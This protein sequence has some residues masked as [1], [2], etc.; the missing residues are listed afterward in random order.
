M[1][2]ECTELAA[3]GLESTVTV[4]IDRWGVP[5]IAASSRRD[6]FFAQGF[7]AA[8]DRLFQLDLWRRRGLGLLADVLGRDYVA[9]DRAA[10]LFLYR[11]ALTDE[12]AAYGEHA[13]EI[14]TAFTDGI[15]EW[16]ARTESDPRLLPPEFERLAFRPGRWRPEDVVRIRT[17]GMFGNLEQQVLR[18]VTLRELGPD[19]EDLRKHRQ[20]PIDVVVPDGLDLNSIDESVLD[21][22]RLAL[23][24]AISPAGVGARPP[25]GSNNWVIS[26]DRTSTR[27]PLLASDPHRAMTVPS[28]RYLVHL[29][30]PGID[31]IGAGEP[32]LPGVSIG[33]NEHVAF[34]LTSWPCSQEDLYVYE[35]HPTDRLHYRYR[36]AWEPFTTVTEAVAVADGS[37][38][39]VELMF[40]R[41]GPVIRWDAE[42]G[43]AFAVRA[44]GLE[45]GMAPYLSSLHY[46]DARSAADF[47]DALAHWRAPSVNQVYADVAGEIGWRGCALV[48][49]RDNWDGLLPVP[50]DG[51]YEWSGFRRAEELP[52]VVNPA[53][54]WFASA[55]EMNLDDVHGWQAIPISYE[56]LAPFRAQRI[57]E[58]LS[59]DD[60]MSVASAAALQNDY[61]SIPARAVCALLPATSPDGD[62]AANAGLRLL[63]GWEHTMTADSAAA[64]LFDDWFRGEL[65]ERSYGEALAPFV[66]ADRSVDA[67]RRAMP[68]ESLVGDAT[69]DMLLL[70]RLGADSHRLQRLLCESLAAT[71]RRL[72][73]HHGADETRWRYGAARHTR[74]PHL[75]YGV[76]EAGDAWRATPPDPK[77]GSPDTVGVAVFDRRTHDQVLGASFRTVIDV[78]AWD[79]SIAI[80]T[81]GQSGDPRS[82]HYADLYATWLRDGYFPL[83]YS[84]EEIA[85]HVETT[86][87]LRPSVE[88]D[89]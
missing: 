65:R 59:R 71:V 78:G 77:S 16:I 76:T 70:E 35:L 28:L 44:A 54:G 41:H 10:R 17:H 46:L 20:P 5:H 75:A 1:K 61:V 24:P 63:R 66:P 56:W 87:T 81:P 43:V 15:N 6:L 12:W 18:A 83:C 74:L 40:T 48:P 21:V 89:S 88:R 42:R 29:R 84:E 3:D 36:D 51:R 33:H 23:G 86:L 14:V 45:P 13:E 67:V 49:V 22:Y 39:T 32:A 58:V 82:A 31:V 85:K 53:T 27:R 11:G 50:G 55:N 19:V 68:D 62:E 80:N 2:P 64:L 37:E 79:E 60:A 25:D 52:Q 7:V 34:G 30:C 72:R 9:R 47:R 4:E 73:S 57:A 69:V 38:Q 26:A 8:R